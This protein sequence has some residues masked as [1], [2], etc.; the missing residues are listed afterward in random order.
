MRCLV[1]GAVGPPDLIRPSHVRSCFL[2][3]GV[4][5][6]TPGVAGRSTGVWCGVAEYRIRK[7]S[8]TCDV[9]SLQ[10]NVTKNY[11]L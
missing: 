11:I 8:P 1:R 3:P 5:N 2:S 9:F 10:P 4:T 6:E 7:A